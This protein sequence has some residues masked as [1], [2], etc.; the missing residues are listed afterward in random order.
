MWALRSKVF[1]S[2]AMLASGPA[3][4]VVDAVRGLIM[5]RRAGIRQGT[6]WTSSIGNPGAD[7][8]GPANPAPVN[9]GTESRECALSEPSDAR[10]DL[11][12]GL[13]PDE[14]L[15]VGVVRGDELA[16]DS[17]QRAHAPIRSERC[18]P[19]RRRRRRADRSSCDLRNSFLIV[20]QLVLFNGLGSSW[21]DRCRRRLLA[22]RSAPDRATC[23]SARPPG[24]ASMDRVG[25]DECE[26][27]RSGMP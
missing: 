26:R 19:L 11:V 13:G 5:P 24:R 7:G 10:Q 20:S 18:G 3:D 12:G 15:G 9:Q 25:P 22:R 17:F 1:A 4:H 21:Y 2:A 8:H 16:N 27:D 14:G 23:R 6:F